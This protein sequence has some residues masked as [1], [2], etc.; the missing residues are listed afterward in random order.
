MWIAAARP[1]TLPAAVVPVWV[2][3]LVAYE[4]AG[5]WDVWLAVCTLLSA[6][7]IQV[8]TNFFNDAIDAGKGADG[9]DRLGPR[10]A[11]GSG[12]VSSQTMLWAGAVALAIATAFGAVLWA[13]VGWPIVLIGLVS[14]YFAF[15]YTGGKMPLAYVGLGEVF[16]VLFFGFVAVSGT[17]FVQ[18]GEWRAEALL[19]GAQVGLLSAV[20]I[21]VN[22]LRDREGDAVVGK[23]TL[24]VRLGLFGARQVVIW[25][26]ALAGALAVCWAQFGSDWAKWVFTG[27]PSLTLGWMVVWQ[28]LSR[29]PSRH[30]NATLATGALML[31]S[32][33]VVVTVL[34][35]VFR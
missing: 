1:K 18:L 30:L 14:C 28:V 27:L 3:C 33:A 29:P 24:A 15:G 17:V 13:A 21:S 10:R 32:F 6:V 22:N 12:D 25:E 20:L 8:A 11:T 9:K 34:E 19:A 7:S 31:V 2:G 4:I 26:V 35:G 23:R 5:Q 16:V